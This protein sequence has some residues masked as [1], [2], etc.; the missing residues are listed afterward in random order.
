MHKLAAIICVIASLPTTE[1]SSAAFE[2][3]AVNKLCKVA[4]ALMAVPKFFEE[5]QIALQKQI[6]AGNDAAIKALLAATTTRKHNETTVYTAVAIAALNCAE[7]ATKKLTDLVPPA[8]KAMTNAAKAA[9][10]ITEFAEFLR[11]VSI[12]RSTGY[13][14]STGTTVKQCGHWCSREVYGVISRI[15]SSRFLLTVI[16]FLWC[17]LVCQTS[18]QHGMYV[19]LRLPHANSLRGYLSAIE[20]FLSFRFR[21]LSPIANIHLTC[22]RV[23]LCHSLSI[24]CRVVQV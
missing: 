10:G 5:K 2:E 14:L 21:F 7:E 18:V 19:F 6:T 12:G 8:V 20:S 1:A 24:S 23:M 13:C 22:W 11:K 4:S 15:S 3:T 16:A 17:V 9:G